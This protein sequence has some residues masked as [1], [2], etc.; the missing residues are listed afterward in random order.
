VPAVFDNSKLQRV[1]PG[2]AAKTPFATGIRRTITWFEADPA[3]HQ[4]DAR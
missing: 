4:I 3:R 1:V 2:F